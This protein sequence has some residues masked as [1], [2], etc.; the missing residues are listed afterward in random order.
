MTQSLQSRTF[1]RSL[2]HEELDEYYGVWS[3]I[4]WL[5]VSHFPL[6]IIEQ[7]VV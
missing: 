7:A 6:L 3:D 2:V 4:G 5:D 1:A